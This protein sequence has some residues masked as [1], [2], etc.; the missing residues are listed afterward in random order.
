MS[1]AV[2]RN[3]VWSTGTGTGT[4]SHPPSAVVRAAMPGPPAA[5]S[6]FSPDCQWTA[7]MGLTG[8]PS[9]ANSIAGCSTCVHV[10]TDVPEF[11]LSRQPSTLHD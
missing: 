3:R 6:C 9:S 10:T 11:V 2:Q 7:V 5:R 4:Q 1:A 8:K